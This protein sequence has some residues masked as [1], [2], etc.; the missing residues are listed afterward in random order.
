MASTTHRAPATAPSLSANDAN[1]SVRSGLPSAAAAAIRR[2]QRELRERVSSARA[3]AQRSAAVRSIAALVRRRARVARRAVIAGSTQ[4]PMD[5]DTSTQR[6]AVPST[7][8]TTEAPSPPP[9]TY[10]SSLSELA[11]AGTNAPPPPPPY[12]AAIGQLAAQAGQSW[13][14]LSRPTPP[15]EKLLPPNSNPNDLIAANSRLVWK[16]DKLRPMQKQALDIVLDPKKS[17]RKVLV[18]ERTGGGKSHIYAALGTLLRGIHVVIIPILSLMADIQ[19]K[20]AHGDESYGAIEVLNM[21]EIGGTRSVRNRVL[22]K[23]RARL[24]TSSTTTFLLCSP[25][26][27]VD[28]PEFVNVLVRV[29]IAKRT[30]RSVVIDEAHLYAL[31]GMSFRADMRVLQDTFFAPLFAGGKERNTIFFI[32]GTATMSA[33]LLLRLSSLTHVGFPD[34]HR[35]WASADEFQQDYIQMSFVPGSNYTKNLDLLVNFVAT[36][37]GSAFLYCNSKVQ[38][39][40]MVENLELKLDK[41]SL[42]VDVVHIHGSLAKEE[43]FSHTKLFCGKLVVEGYNPRIMVGTASADHGIDRPDGRLMIN[44]EWP[45]TLMIWTQRKGRLSRDLFFSNA[46]LHAGV[47]AYIAMMTHIDRNKMK[48]QSILSS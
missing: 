20:F 44:Y 1:A 37:R 26:F 35:V 16:V 23:L 24:R 31:H 10:A 9:P 39:H 14:A 17:N 12:S 2:S 30:L 41:Q 29:C 5:V 27:L 22:A 25:Q 47:A 32:A 42:R 45:E 34:A 21:D 11:T 8:S 48:V 19:H 40:K 7:A 38:T 13:H 15:A 36:K 28:Y 18:V 4:R 6:P 46:I 43:K 33:P 3:S